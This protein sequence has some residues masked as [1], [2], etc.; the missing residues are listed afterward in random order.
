MLDR[1]RCERCACPSLAPKFASARRC[2]AS[3]GSDPM[4]VHAVPNSGQEN[5]L[6]GD[7][8]MAMHAALNS[9]QESVY[10]TTLLTN[11]DISSRPACLFLTRAANLKDAPRLQENGERGVAWCWVLRRADQVQPGQVP[12]VVGA[13]GACFGARCVQGSWTR[14]GVP[15]ARPAALALALRLLHSLLSR[16]LLSR[17][18]HPPRARA[19]RSRSRLS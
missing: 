9:V 4:S 10:R 1:L 5:A 6:N 16:R 2:A 13:R 15:K 11:A 18:P 3:N 17:P 12:G 14:R 19:L 7:G 8:P